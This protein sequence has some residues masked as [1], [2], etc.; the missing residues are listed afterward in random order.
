MYAGAYQEICVDSAAFKKVKKVANFFDDDQ[1]DDVGSIEAGNL[2]DGVVT[3]RDRKL[4]Q[5]KTL[6]LFFFPHL[7]V[8]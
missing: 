7:T 1:V 2:C 3:L 6:F 5:K 8:F 4:R